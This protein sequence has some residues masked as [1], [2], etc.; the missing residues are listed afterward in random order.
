MKNG[1]FTALLGLVLL[2]FPSGLRAQD[3]EIQQLL[4]NVQK[5]D[6]LKDVLANME[7]K[8]RILSQGY[9]QVKSMTEG[10]FR[11]HEAFLGR[12]QQVNP[13]V[14]SYYKVGE[15]IALQIRIIKG[16]AESKNE[17][18][19]DEFF[20]SGELEGVLRIYS[21]FSTSSLKNLEELTLVLSDR[22]LQMDDWE[23]LQSIDRIHE[24]MLGLA[25]GLSRFHVSLADLTSLRRAHGLENKT[26]KQILGHD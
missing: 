18:Q 17:L 22:Q 10:N 3:A 8:Y 25:Q 4:L 14:K 5:L 11:M 23:R 9:Q 15:I 7:Q 20:D 16:I 21:S 12:L 19:W 26:I 24:S 6:Q 1:L 2:G 13:Q